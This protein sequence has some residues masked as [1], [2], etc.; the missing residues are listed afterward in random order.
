[1][2]ENPPSPIHHC[3]RRHMREDGDSRHLLFTYW[4]VILPGHP[5]ETIPKA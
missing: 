2:T 1:M 3:Q 4:G 5:G